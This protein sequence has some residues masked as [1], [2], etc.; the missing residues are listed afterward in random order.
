MNNSTMPLGEKIRE[1]RKAKGLSVENMAQAV[2]SFK[3]NISRLERGIADITPAMLTGIKKFL[4]IE[5]APLLEHELQL[6]RNRIWVWNDL[7]H[8]NRVAEARAMQS[9]M[10]VI[11]NL[12]FEYDLYMLYLV[13]EVW[14]LCKEY[15]FPAAGDK[16][17]AVEGLLDNV[18]NTSDEALNLYHRSKGLLYLCAGDKNN[19]INH[20]LR[21]LDYA[22]KCR[23]ADT[24]ALFNLGQA[25]CAMNKPCQSIIYMER[26][27]ALFQ[28]GPSHITV[29]HMNTV[30]AMCYKNI[31]EYSIARKL[32]ES[33]LAQA[34]SVNN[35]STIGMTLTN[36]SALSLAKGDYEEGISLCDQA[37]I[38]VKQNSVAYANSL[39]IKAMCLLSLAKLDKCRE[40]LTLATTML[41]EANQGAL[42]ILIGSKDVALHLE[43]I[44]H[45]TTLDNS[46]SVKYILDV[47]IPHLR[48]GGMTKF[49]AIGLC[50]RLEAHFIKRRAKTKANAV[51]AIARDIYREVFL[52]EVVVE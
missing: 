7:L 20:S 48:A 33:A 8:H 25:Y 34:R 9:E 52:E 35:E 31:G 43:A 30:L 3:A 19:C 6:Y 4:E 27:K 10:A 26:A 5:T 28:G 47:A 42:T 50:N 12:P 11:M 15:N 44:G 41:E 37:E 22:E 38:Y 46:D 39:A 36:M 18:D 49:N 51:A 1:I 40:V 21:A 24:S 2:G 29:G 16:L 45:L 13:T 17:K 14:L 32:Y 23:K